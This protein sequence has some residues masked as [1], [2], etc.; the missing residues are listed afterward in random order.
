MFDRRLSRK[1]TVGNSLGL[2]E[3]ESTDMLRTSRILIL[4]YIAIGVFVAWDRHYITLPWLR[5]LASALLS[6]FL[7]FLILLGVNLHVHG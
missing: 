5:S 3:T 2:Q 6:I 7:W 1:L 4:I